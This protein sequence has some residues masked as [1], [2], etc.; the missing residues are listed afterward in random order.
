MGG[1]GGRVAA[2]IGSCKVRRDLPPG[3]P[4]VEPLACA[5]TGSPTGAI[6]GSACTDASPTRVQRVR[7]RVVCSAATKGRAHHGSRASR[8]GALRSSWTSTERSVASKRW[9]R[10]PGAPY[11]RRA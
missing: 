7:W 3:R 1:P 9:M 10:T 4:L 6:P 5:A 8:T 11:F 2:A